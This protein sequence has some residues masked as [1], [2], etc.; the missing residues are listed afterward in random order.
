[1][2]LNASGCLDALTAPDVARSLD[3]F[4]TKTVTPLPREGNIPI[5]IAETD[6]GML[7]S[8]GLANPGI[9]RF[10]T[11]NL[12]R[13]EELGV[14]VWVSVGGFEI[15]DYAETCSR[16]DDH[17]VVS[18][19][20]LNVSCPNVEAPAES[21]A[22]IVAA[23]RL[24]TRKPLWAKLSPAVPDIAEVARAA[25]SA[26]ADGLSLVNTV[27]GLALDART[28]RPVLA[29][30][31][32]GLSG[33]ALK[34][35]A[36]A[37]VASCYRATQLPIVGMGGVSTGLDALELI[38]VGARHVALGTVLF[39]DPD[40]P[41]RV[42]AELHAAATERGWK[43]YEDAYAVAHEESLSVGTTLD[44]RSSV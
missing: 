18:A 23:A 44:G 14:P 40:A 25:Q 37:A 22:Q 38:A 42:R 2:L 13:L 39:A 35:I 4:V 36:L 5:R 26:G 16:L 1:M 41:A 21:A 15:D 11:R 20:E 9:D 28:L 30:G 27:R 7:N 17:E 12:P 6:V 34:P 29:P 3:V 32:G 43:T 10:V 19:I 24:A 33:P 31:H 8:I